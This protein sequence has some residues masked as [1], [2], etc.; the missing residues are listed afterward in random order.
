MIVFAI[1]I[2]AGLACQSAVNAKL[3][4]YVLSPFTASM[5]S[6]FVGACILTILSFTSGFLFWKEWAVLKGEPYWLLCGGLLGVFSLTMNIILFQKVGG[7]MAAVLPIFGQVVM[8]TLIDQFGWF[9]SPI[10]P[11][12]VIKGIGLVIV[13]LGVLLAT[14]SFKKQESAEKSQLGWKIVGVFAGVAVATQATVNGQLAAILQ[15][16]LLSTQISFY[17]GLIALCLIVLLTKSP[18]KTI[19][20]AVAVPIKQYW[21]FLGGALGAFY[22]FGAAKLAPIIGTGHFVIYAL[23]GQL[24]C[25]MLIDHF[26]LLHAP[27]KRVSYSKAVG[28][29]TML[30]GIILMKL[31]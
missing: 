19:Q 10:D 8:G 5:I 14:E 16:T 9:A 4:S 18:I 25:S 1:I 6:F 3:R 7:V 20:N 27:V 31:I 30:I 15:S 23:F 22:V 29:V 12:T 21:I 2:G 26:G 13:L 11:L 28:L 17:I 24:V